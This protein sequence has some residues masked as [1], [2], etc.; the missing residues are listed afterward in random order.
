MSYTLL[1][2]VVVI[3]LIGG[4]ISLLGKIAKGGSGEYAASVAA[5]LAIAGSGVVLGLFVPAVIE[6]GTVV[7]AIGGWPEPYGITMVLD[8]YAWVSSMLTVTIALPV[9]VAALSRRRY[10]ARFFFFLLLLVAG[11]LSVSLTGDLFTMFVSF[12]IVA[13]AA[14]VPIAF[15]KSDE[16]MVASIKYLILSTVGILFFLFGVFLIYRDLGI[17]SISG[18]ERALAA[19]PSTA[20]APAI[21]LA[22]AAL[23]V[24]I[25]VRTAF[26]PFHTWLPEAHAYAPH[27][28]SALL[29]GAL[30][31]VSIFALFRILT[32]FSGAYLYNLLLWIGGA[33]ALLAVIFALAQSDT[34][35]LL[36]FHSVSQMGYVLAAFASA[37]EISL[38]ASLSHAVNHALFKSLLFLAVGTAI[39]MTGERNLYAMKPVGRK[40]PLLALLFFVGALAISGVPPFNGFAS[41][42]FVIYS[43]AGSPVS[44]LLWITGAATIASFIKL[45]RVFSFGRRREKAVLVAGV[46]DAIPRQGAL[47]TI[48]MI[49]LAASCILTGVFAVPFTRM[50]HTLTGSGP[51]PYL[52]A[53]YSAKKLL[54]V[55]AAAA[56]GT[57]LYFLITS[58]VGMRFTARIKSYAPDMRTVLLLFFLGL[59][60]FSAV[61]YL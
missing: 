45:S 54:S 61:A 4:G 10:G 57:V 14:Y 31:K 60:G 42:S 23:C 30:I 33:T 52:P 29:S 39:Q 7:C 55:A 34:K 49:F 17:L 20:E 35:R 16:G 25:G 9:G 15:E 41:K 37:R 1:P 47:V 3:P 2:L 51:T 21:H 40:A 11:M 24:G 38:T 59:V 46:P 48:S 43:T 18:I 32:L 53:L 13:I 27:T 36:A 8:G 22:I 6:G 28:I 44:V 12:E 50:L 19:A 58:P 5:V 56:T 26:L